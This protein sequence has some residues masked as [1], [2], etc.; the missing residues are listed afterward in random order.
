MGA[1][2]SILRGGSGVTGGGVGMRRLIYVALAVALIFVIFY[3]KRMGDSGI[4]YSNEGINVVP[5][6]KDEAVLVRTPDGHQ[7]GISYAHPLVRR[8]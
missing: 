3:G 5:E 4:K 2:A 7:Y 8:W 6:K 1:Y